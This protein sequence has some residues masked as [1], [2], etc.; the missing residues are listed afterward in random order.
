MWMWIVSFIP[1][2]GD[3]PLFLFCP[4]KFTIE[5][6]YGWKHIKKKFSH[7]ILQRWEDLEPK[8]QGVCNWINTLALTWVTSDMENNQYQ[9][10]D[11]NTEMYAVEKNIKLYTR[12]QQLYL[13]ESQI[14]FSGQTLDTHI[15]LYNNNIFLFYFIIWS[16][17]WS[18][19]RS[20][21]GWFS[22]LDLARGPPV[23]YHICKHFAE[24]KSNGTTI[25]LF[26]C[27]FLYIFWWY[28][29]LRSN[30]LTQS[31]LIKSLCPRVSQTKAKSQIVI[32]SDARISFWNII[33]RR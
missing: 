16:L 18:P 3:Y 12:G 33:E 13:S 27:F 7:S 20:W 28:D 21:T 2:A 4:Q 31:W 25:F 23:D 14:F 6:F 30:V 5:H 19:V 11:T 10:E 9:K 17:S 15:E 8:N 29:D 1:P 24:D 22:G 32:A 26:F